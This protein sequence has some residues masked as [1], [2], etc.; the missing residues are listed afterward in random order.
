MTSR[1]PR[2][3]ST[4]LPKGVLA[5]SA[6][7]R[8]SAGKAAM[9]GGSSPGSRGP[10]MT[11][12]RWVAVTVALLLVAVIAA[13]FT[14]LIGPDRRLAA[15]RNLQSQLFD[16]SLTPE[17]RQ[18]A[19]AELRQKMDELPDDLKFKAMMSRPGGGPGG[20]FGPGG[21][22]ERM[23][24]LFAM[25]EK[26]RIAEVDKQLDRMVD[27][28]KR[29]E[30]AQKDNAA[31]SNAQ[32][33]SNPSQGGT[34]SGANTP[35]GAAGQP[36]G[37]P[38]SG[39]PPGGF[40]APTETQANQWRNRMLSSVPA[41]TRSTMRMYGQLFQARALQRGIQLPGPPGPR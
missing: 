31:R 41:E 15:I 25:P 3:P 16:E 23:K 13:W 4:S 30:Q 19:G 38:G 21:N 36:G 28:M 20:G 24:K 39:P 8:P 1:T 40:R 32:A 14:G 7:A 27:G 5:R 17:E 34:K 9:R 29:W 18:A 22:E 2:L 37:G 11:R 12:G 26:E 10:R 33:G 6:A 35:G